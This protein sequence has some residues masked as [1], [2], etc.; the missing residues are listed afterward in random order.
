[1]LQSS[2]GQLKSGASVSQKQPLRYEALPEDLQEKVR[3]EAALDFEDL[4]NSL[5]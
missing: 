3:E 1:M 5:P 2:E 4:N